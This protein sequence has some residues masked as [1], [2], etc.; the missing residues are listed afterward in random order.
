M[1][2]D[3][4]KNR[5]EDKPWSDIDLFDLQSNIA[6]GDLVEET[7]ELLMRREGEVREKIRELQLKVRTNV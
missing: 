3:R 7:A 1:P 2:E 6:R 5:N 4:V